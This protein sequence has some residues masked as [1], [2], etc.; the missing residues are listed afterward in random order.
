MMQAWEIQCGDIIYLEGNEEFPCDMVLLKSSNADGS[1]YVQTANVDGETDLKSR[2]SLAATQ[3]ISEES[4]LAF[5]AC[6]VCR[7][8]NAEIYKFDSR[9][10]LERDSAESE[11]LSLGTSQFLLQGTFLRNTDFVYGLAVYT[12]NETKLGLN[13]A[14]PPFKWT[15]L[16]Q[17]V[18]RASSFIFLLQLTVAVILGIVGNVRKSDDDKKWYLGYEHSKWIDALVIPLRFLLL[19]SLMIPISL[20]VTMDI[21]KYLYA[22]FID[23]DLNMYDKKTDTPANATSTALSED[24]GQVAYIF[25]DK[26]GTLTENV[27]NF[28]KCSIGGVVFGNVLGAGSATQDPALLS[29][30]QIACGDAPVTSAMDRSDSVTRVP[31]TSSTVHSAAPTVALNPETALDF[32]RA[33]ALCQTVVPVHAGDRSSMMTAEGSD[34]L[35]GIIYRAASPD[36][37]ALVRAAAAL[38]VRFV[39]RD[40]VGVE[41]RVGLSGGVERYEVLNTLSFSSDRRRMSVVLRELPGPR[42]GQGGRIRIITKG[43][44]DVIMARLSQ[45]DADIAAASRVQIDAFAS[46]GLRTLCLAHRYLTAEE[47]AEWTVRFQLANRSLADRDQALD[48][49]YELLESNLRLLGATAI[50]DRLQDGVP[51]TISRLR[52]A[53]IRF[54]MLTGDKYST[55]IQIATSCNLMAPAPE[56][57]LLTIRG[58]SEEEIGTS[59]EQTSAK[60]R[61]LPPASRYSVIIEGSS[62][63]HV[64]SN[65]VTKAE[66]LSLGLAAQTVICCRVTPAQKGSVV[67]LARGTEHVTLAIGDGGNDV[68]MIQKAHVGVGI[69]GKE[70]LQAARAADYSIAKFR[71]LERL[72]LIHGR[73]SFKRTSFIA[74][75]S[76]QKSLYICFIQIFFAFMSGFSGAS[77]FNSTSLT[78]Y[79]ILFTGLPIVLYCLD[80]DVD[81]STMIA[82]PDLLRETQT[83]STFSVR[84]FF[85]WL[86][87]ALYQSLVTLFFFV[88]FYDP[89]GMARKD[90]TTFDQECVSV[91]AFAAAVCVQ[92]LNLALETNSFTWINHLLIW[93][94]APLFFLVFL[95]ASVFPRL[96]MYG[97][98]Q[99]LLGD[100]SFWLLLLLTVTACMFPFYAS[101]FIRMS[102][103]PSP[104]DAVRL[105]KLRQK[106]DESNGGLMEPLLNRH[107]PH[108]LEGSN[109]ALSESDILLAGAARYDESHSHD[110]TT[111]LLSGERT[112]IEVYGSGGSAS[113]L[114]KRKWV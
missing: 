38:G 96:Q 4:F 63:G 80:K 52:S 54:W 65:H 31:S 94:Q 22:M 27:M 85:L 99:Q 105:N 2:I 28:Q 88:A 59:L 16:D 46:Q 5:S 83:S 81:E 10:H 33:M 30:L 32:V 111:P 78:T 13:K 19:L 72:I 23:W 43:A 69:V 55:A 61:R 114:D 107:S 36:E 60:V 101:K 66:F 35:K 74:L 113:S 29:T 89:R 87:R 108:P 71:Y 44:D 53:N 112:S 25:T 37:E 76:F 12:G 50:E 21:C 14:T 93:I 26:T 79:N 67:E 39:D 58:S 84:L 45:A 70:G 100:A 77:F 56:G 8:P 104:H 110:S 91:G 73:Y 97:V 90:G 11:A 9:L 7:S 57:Q 1:C 86:V 40:S 92:T 98:M 17:Q 109:E 51:Q 6:V 24:L 34:V 95:A 82:N 103:F 64:L 20:K 68:A 75:Y 42:L 49:V 15:R 41:V 48:A 47:Y 102:Y 62:L 106:D 3:A 18:N